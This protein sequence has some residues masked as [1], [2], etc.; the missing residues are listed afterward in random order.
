MP[1]VARTK[2]NLI[3]KYA[4][5]AF[6]GKH[7]S[8]LATRRFGCKRCSEVTNTQCV[9][10]FPSKS[11]FFFLSSSFICWFRSFFSRF[12]LRCDCC[13]FNRKSVF[14]YKPVRDN[15]ERKVHT[16]TNVTI[17]VALSKPN[18]NHCIEFHFVCLVTVRERHVF[19]YAASYLILQCLHYSISM[20]AYFFLLR[21]LNWRSYCATHNKASTSN[22]ESFHKI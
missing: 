8:I 5:C 22:V 15:F 12:P 17:F 9:V 19:Q 3:P 16:K 11:F 18:E 1:S 20:S 14:Q 10:L 21:W 2:R 13:A 6:N 7:L 4:S